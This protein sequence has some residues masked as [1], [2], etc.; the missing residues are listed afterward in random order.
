MFFCF[1]SI[2]FQFFTCCRTVTSVEKHLLVFQLPLSRISLFPVDYLWFCCK[3]HDLTICV[4]ACVF[5]SHPRSC[6][7]CLR[8]ISQ[9]NIYKPKWPLSIMLVIW[10]KGEVFSK[11]STQFKAIYTCHSHHDQYHL[12]F[13]SVYMCIHHYGSN[14]QGH[15]R[16]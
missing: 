13:M 7:I 2:C 14:I 16:P 4:L 6:Q 12:T 9:A 3:K 5:I 15:R 1:A 8:R 11:L 10:K